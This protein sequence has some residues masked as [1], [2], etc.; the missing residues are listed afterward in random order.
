MNHFRQWVFS[1]KSNNRLTKYFN[2][3]GTLFQ[4]Y[5]CK[6]IDLNDENVLKFL[7]SLMGRYIRSVE[8]MAD[9]LARTRELVFDTL[10]KGILIEK[11][12]LVKDATFIDDDMWAFEYFWR[13]N[14]EYTLQKI[15][16]ENNTNSQRELLTLAYWQRLRFKS[17]WND[18]QI[19]WYWD[20]IL[21]F[22][23]F[24]SF[25]LNFY[26]TCRRWLE[27]WLFVRPVC[28]GP[29]RKVCLTLRM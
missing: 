2:A 27:H 14:C 7:R 11:I 24:L 3:I 25:Q 13:K 23:N 9:R 12:M 1:P 8:I 15:H 10:F 17:R 29:T 19:T 5:D 6:L 4:E 28:I 20:L 26:L 16:S 21:L 22:P 18:I